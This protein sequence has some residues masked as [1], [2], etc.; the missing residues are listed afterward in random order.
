MS[1][2]LHGNTGVII[3][4]IRYLYDD[5]GQDAGGPLHVILD[6]GNVA[7]WVIDG[8]GPDRYTYLW[9]GTFEAYADAGDDTSERRRQAIQVTCEKIVEL[10]RPMSEDQRRDVINAFWKEWR[11]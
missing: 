11:P 6:D 3:S 10:L 4:L 1:A 5:L 8:C 7:D 2:D 9:D